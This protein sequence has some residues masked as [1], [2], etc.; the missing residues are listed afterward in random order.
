MVTPRKD[1]EKLVPD[2]SAFQALWERNPG[3]RTLASA[4]LYKWS[5]IDII[6]FACV[7]GSLLVAFRLPNEGPYPLIAKVLLAVISVAAFRYRL[8]YAPTQ[9]NSTDSPAEP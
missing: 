8:K 5:A 2:D 6:T 1:T 9:K 3:W 7:S 4:L